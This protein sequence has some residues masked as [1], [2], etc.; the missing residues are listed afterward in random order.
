MA[1]VVKST[2]EVV[3]IN[4][5]MEKIQ[6]KK[7]N[8]KKEKEQS[9]QKKNKNEKVVKNTDKKKKTGKD[10]KDK[11]AKKV[12][13]KNPVFTF[14]AEVRKEVSK[15]KWPSR[16]D[17]IKYSIATISFIVFFALFFFIIDMIM[18]ILLGV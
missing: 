5:E 10:K 11:K 13:K 3:D 8:S 9:D 1:K 18:A 15:V 2:R 4:E 14:F 17:M 6:K 12:K 16:R 7:K